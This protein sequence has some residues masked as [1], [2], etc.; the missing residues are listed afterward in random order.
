MYNTFGGKGYTNSLIV[1]NIYPFYDY[2]T[3]FINPM[4][5]DIVIRTGKENKNFYVG[6]DKEESE[7][8][9]DYISYK[10][11]FG[12]HYVQYP[13]LTRYARNS[14]GKY[15]YS[16]KIVNSDVIYF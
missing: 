10:D 11:I 3:Y 16:D 9:G 13:T 14:D 1:G 2:D 5:G 8:L 15:I 6:E 12:P 4:T 7:E